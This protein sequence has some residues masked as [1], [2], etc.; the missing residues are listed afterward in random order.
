[1]LTRRRLITSLAMG[2]CA[3]QLQ[4]DAAPG[5][6]PPGRAEFPNVVLLNQHGE[7]LR[8]FD[9]FIRGDR[10][11][12]IGFIYA[13][14]GDI[15]PLTMSNL[16]LVQGLLGERLGRDVHLA[17][18][19][20]DPV[21]DSATVLKGYADRFDARPGWLFLTGKPGDIDLIRRGLG[22]YDRDPVIDSDRTQHTGMLVYGNQA[23]GRWGRVSAL[24]KPPQI[25]ASITR[26][27]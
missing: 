22:A 27:T 23:R 10:T 4:A 1:M 17:S 8:F 3:T 25:L 5:T 6:T 14:C 26:W 19:S 12:V 16:A 21:R 11:V 24:A 2:T 15:C 13:Q 9:D 7:R 18:I 20:I